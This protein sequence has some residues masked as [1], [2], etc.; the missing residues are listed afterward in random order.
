VRERER[1][2]ERGGAFS[3]CKP[4]LRQQLRRVRGDGKRLASGVGG[5]GVEAGTTN[6]K[7]SKIRF[8][9]R[10][11]KEVSEKMYTFFCLSAGEIDLDLFSKMG[12][13]FTP[14]TFRTYMLE[15]KNIVN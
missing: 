12:W 10:K 14:V 7:K 6:E 5:M 1:E 15:E 4:S 11:E 8:F 2:K 9:K 3:K 13:P